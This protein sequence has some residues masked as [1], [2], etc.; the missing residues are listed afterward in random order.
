MKFMI[1]LALCITI[2]AATF[3]ACSNFASLSTEG[4]SHITTFDNRI[5]N[6]LEEIWNNCHQNFNVQA[7][8]SLDL[9]GSCTKLD[10]AGS[11]DAQELWRAVSAAMTSS[12]SH[13]VTFPEPT[14]VLYSEGPHT[15]DDFDPPVQNCVVRAYT[16]MFFNEISFETLD[17]EWTLRSGEPA[18]KISL[19]NAES[20]RGFPPVSPYHSLL[21]RNTLATVDCPSL[22]SE[23]I[24]ERKLDKWGLDG[25]HKIKFL[26][27]DLDI[28]IKLDVLATIKKGKYRRYLSGDVEVDLKLKADGNA[29][30]VEAE[31]LAKYGFD[32]ADWLETAEE[33]IES[34]VQKDFKDVGKEIA[35]QFEEALP[36]SEMI[37]SSV[38]DGG[39]LKIQT[40][41][42]CGEHS[43]VIPDLGT[44]D[45]T[46]LV[47][48][49]Q[50]VQISTPT[51]QVQTAT[52]Q[53]VHYTVKNK[54]TG[55]SSPTFIALERNGREIARQEIP[56]LS[57]YPNIGNS[58]SGS[59]TE[60][61]QELQ[62]RHYEWIIKVNPDIEIV[63]TDLTNNTDGFTTHYL[64]IDEPDLPD[65][66]DRDN[67]EH[68]L[69]DLA[70]SL[71]LTATQQRE[72]RTLLK[73][74][75]NSIKDLVNREG[76]E[77]G[78]GINEELILIESNFEAELERILTDEQTTQ[79]R[80][81]ASSRTSQQP[82]RR[83]DH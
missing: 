18:L 7:G 44:P 54:G 11:I 29:F 41:R 55:N 40:K 81:N 3:T 61:D 70:G 22:I 47:T 14:D 24:I 30:G 71:N 34:R 16:Q 64:E 32:V 69:K 33:V 57:H 67:I 46:A 45:L 62:G 42:F 51:M 35:S 15:L 4:D 37:C 78:D 83:R 43:E 79:Y 53:Q 75:A 50:L 63:E 59:F 2:T 80:R 1:L 17:A 73:R 9:H 28:Y 10:D 48:G 60:L 58:Y 12:E 20:L 49:K 36:D 23:I 74:H 25:E 77:I 26:D 19:G 72:V 13:A 21:I 52:L 38:V 68:H 8:E 76:Y 56:A 5:P 39:T 82:R 66:V 65:T 31:K 6:A 27:I